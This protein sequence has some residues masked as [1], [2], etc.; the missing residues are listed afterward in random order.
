MNEV[1]LAVASA[2]ALPIRRVKERSSKSLSGPSDKEKGLTEVSAKSMKTEKKEKRKR[3]AK[4]S[5]PPPSL[6]LNPS[7]CPVFFS[8]LAL[9]LCGIGFETRSRALQ[10]MRLRGTGSLAL[11][12]ATLVV[13]LPN[14]E[15]Q[16]GMEIY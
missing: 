4:K 10:L 16:P 12:F 5:H 7:F 11:G 1:C 15:R 14:E 6:S 2:L 13:S 9:C 3:Q 8:P